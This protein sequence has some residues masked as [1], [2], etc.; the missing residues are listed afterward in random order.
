VKT[1]CNLA[2]CSKEGCGSETAVLLMMMMMMIGLNNDSL[3]K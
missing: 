1:G 3:V 2:E